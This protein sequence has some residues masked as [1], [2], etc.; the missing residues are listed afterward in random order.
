[1]C[2]LCLAFLCLGA[3]TSSAV[4]IIAHR[5]AS[6]DAPENTLASFRL[7]WQQQA[8]ADEL[9]IWLSQDGQIVVIHDDNTKRVAGVDKKVAA[10]TLA[11]LRALDVGSWKG[12]QW[13]GEKLPTLAEALATIPT[14][15]RM[16]IEI[17]CGVEVLPALG[18][19]IQ[20]SG[21]APEQL[22][23]IAFSYRVAAAAKTEFPQIEVS[24]LYDWKKDK[25][26]GLK[27]TVDELI[28]RAKEA[29]VDGLDLEAKGPID[30][31]FVRKARTANL[32]LYVWT[33][34]DPVL[35]KRLAAAGVDGITTNR[36]QWLREQ[37]KP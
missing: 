6:H 11:E 24:W 28:T 20:A 15:R 29:G 30:A 36:P 34:D 23:I 19:A 7:G 25:D 18:R 10:Q 32:K 21:K 5:G 14:G 27:F 4:E 13:A 17:K 16:F 2:K 12:A 35:A 8:D 31:A 1:M 37:L 3:L 9:D 33:V 22:A 26:S